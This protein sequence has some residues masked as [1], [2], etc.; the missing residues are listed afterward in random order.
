VRRRRHDSLLE[1]GIVVYER[2][3]R[4][5]DAYLSY[6][7]RAWP[8]TGVLIDTRR[9]APVLIEVLS[10]YNPMDRAFTQDWSTVLA[11]G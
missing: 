11:R 2:L 7:K 6:V 10:D 4:E 3:R 5:I 1:R 9:D 8:G